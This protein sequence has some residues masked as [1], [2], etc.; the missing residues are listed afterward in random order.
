MVTPH[1]QTPRRIRAAGL[2]ALA[3]AV[4]AGAQAP[5]R[6]PAHTVAD[7][8]WISGSWEMTRGATRVEE[9]WTRPAANALLGMGRRLNGE[10]MVFFEFLRIEQRDD[11]IYYVAQPRGRAPTDFKLTRFDG[12]SAVFENPQHDF[13]KRVLYRK[14]PDGSL[15]ARVDGGE[16]APGRAEDFHYRPLRN[17]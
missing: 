16:A 3:L 5:P 7:L 6:A 10:R 2:A 8:A 12:S 9:H 17:P 4:V 11:G 14:N 15:T 1:A 13:P